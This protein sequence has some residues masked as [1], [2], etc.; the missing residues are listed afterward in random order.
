M[1]S[2]FTPE[3]RAAYERDGCV[4]VPGLFDTEATG[5][6]RQ[7]I[8][9]DPQLSANLYERKDAEG[10]ATRMALWNHPGDRVYG[11]AARSLRMVDTVED[12]LGG[13]VYHY[14]SK[15]T[16][17][18][19]HDGGA[20]EWHQDYGCWYHNGCLYPHMA[21]VMLALDRADRDNGCLQVL[22]GSHH[23]GRIDQGSCP[24]S[25]LAPTHDASSRC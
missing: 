3:R 14:H 25:R 4:I 6:L 1:T 7:A 16:A 19:P 22:R 23:A 10:K 15:L 12:M 21:S 9:L 18:E 11:L 20:W 24:A 8:E 5:L 13:E 17:K 2:V